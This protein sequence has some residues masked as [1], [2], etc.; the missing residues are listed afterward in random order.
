MA[1]RSY[2]IVDIEGIGKANAKKL[3]KAN[4]KTTGALLRECATKKGRAA[5]AATS[6]I[7][8]KR[9]LKWTN[10]A[11]LMR[12]KGVATQFS[13]LLEAAGVDTIK[14]LRTR[15][16]DNLAAAMAKANKKKKLARVTPSETVVKGWIAHAKKLANV[17][18]Y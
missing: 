16:P 11:D 15:R 17:I 3:A 4:I 18:K 1:Y 13:E 7:D 8:E 6:R 12:V 10:L 14:E 2:S 5:V 9:I